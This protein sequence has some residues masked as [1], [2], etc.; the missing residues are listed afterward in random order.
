MN[1]GYKFI[2]EQAQK[3]QKETK[4]F[5]GKLKAKAPKDLDA[6]TH[7][8]HDKA[9]ENID[10]LQCANCCRTIGPLLL[11]K[12]IERLATENKMR[13]AVFAEKYLRI[14]EDNDYV[15]K[16]MPCPFLMADN[17]CSVYDAR[18]N[19]CRNFPH[20][21]QRNILQKLKITYN[22]A[23]ICPAVA[24]VVDGLKKHYG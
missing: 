4:K 8:L 17:C 5:L 9:F 18:P 11:D 23:V 7:Q 14:D 24:I 12:D 10:C 15:F 22:N 3:K 21:Q 13:P 19:A 2:L 20:T 1:S 6:V 16:T